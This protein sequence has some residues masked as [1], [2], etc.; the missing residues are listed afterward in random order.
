MSARERCIIA[1]HPHPGRNC[2][3]PHEVYRNRWGGAPAVPPA[4]PVEGQLTLEELSDAE[5]TMPS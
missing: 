3:P 4:E 5:G 2:R 1:E